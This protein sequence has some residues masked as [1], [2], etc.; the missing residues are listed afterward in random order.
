[1]YNVHQLN[2]FT[3]AAETLNFSA[4]AKILQMTQ[5]SVSQHIK[6]LESQLDAGLFHRNG[7]SMELTDT[8]K[9]FL[10]LARTIVKDTIRAQEKMHLL[11]E[12]VFGD[13]IIG[14]NTAPGKYILP[15]MLSEFRKHHP[16]VTITCTVLP[17][18]QILNYLGKGDVHF[19]MINLS[20][21]LSQEMETQLYLREPI[22]L[23]AHPDHAWA[24]RGIIE[25]EELYDEHFILR[26]ATSG[27]YASVQKAL[28]DVGVEISRL[29]ITL[30]MGTSE[31]IALAV[32][33]KL[34]VGF[35]S[36]T[37]ASKICPDRV[38]PVRI[39]GVEISQDIYM[40]RQIRQPATNAQIAFWEFIR[41]TSGMRI[42]L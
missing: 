18:N 36:E 41:T 16:L 3:T 21:G 13:L 6:S 24:Q 23:I 17:Q 38:T 2:V 32:Q 4:A 8:G 10:P 14:C 20:P 9:Y 39:R 42:H 1:M 15:I 26:E 35:V 40:T 34:G 25:P 22:L 7:R 12:Q 27:T 11:K 29:H 33:E 31:A 5:S 30:G 19:A 37:I 28:N